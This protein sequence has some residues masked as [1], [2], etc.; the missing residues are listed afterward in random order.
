MYSN[1]LYLL[2]AICLSLIISVYFKKNKSYLLL[3]TIVLWVLC[4][5]TTIQNNVQNNVE[6]SNTIK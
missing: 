1:Y 4:M 3:H 6:N 2:D 5:V